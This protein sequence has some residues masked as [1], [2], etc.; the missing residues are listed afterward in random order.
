MSKIT[1]REVEEVVWLLDTL[2]VPDHYSKNKIKRDLPSR[3][4]AVFD[5]KDNLESQRDELLEALED[6]VAAVPEL[7]FALNYI[8]GYCDAEMGEFASVEYGKLPQKMS[9]IWHAREVA[10]EAIAKTSK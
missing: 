7:L 8:V 4:M 3:V 5:E 9:V 10:R 6:L 1:E 2:K